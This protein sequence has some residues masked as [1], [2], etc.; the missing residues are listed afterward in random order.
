MSYI[1][2]STSA[3]TTNGL[4]SWLVQELNRI[5]NGFTVAGQTTTLPVLSAE[6][7]KPETGQVVFAD[8]TAWNPG[9]GR[10]LYY[11]DTNAWTHIA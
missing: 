7:P 3:N 2:S 6:P 9:S 10:G 8:G 4:R 1:P 11:Y 5:A